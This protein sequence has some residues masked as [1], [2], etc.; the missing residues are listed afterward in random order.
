MDALLRTSCHGCNNIWER[1]AGRG[2]L[3]ASTG[4]GKW[5][6]YSNHDWFEY[7]EQNQFR[8][9]L[10]SSLE[11]LIFHWLPQLA[12]EKGRYIELILQGFLTEMG[13]EIFGGEVNHNIDRFFWDKKIRLE[14]PIKRHDF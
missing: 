10:N 4:T 8:D 7:L 9:Y 3:G 12:L 1:L 14:F 5:Y 2:S 11:G 6:S 13:L